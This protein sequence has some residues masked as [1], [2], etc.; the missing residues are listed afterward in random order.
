MECNEIMVTLSVWLCM[1]KVSPSYK[2][3]FMLN[4]AEH[5]NFPAHKC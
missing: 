4:S 2:E 1:V 3:N 5:K